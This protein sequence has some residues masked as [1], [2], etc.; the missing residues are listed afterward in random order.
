MIFV[1]LLRGPKIYRVNQEIVYAFGGLW[2]LKACS[3]YLKLK[4][5]SIS[6]RL[7]WKKVSF[8]KVTYLYVPKIRKTA[9]CMGIENSTFHSGP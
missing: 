5:Y 2:K 6:Q 4:C 3:R 8:G 9:G 1:A 7:T